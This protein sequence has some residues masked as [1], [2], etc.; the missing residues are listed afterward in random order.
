MANYFISKENNTVFEVKKDNP[1]LSNSFKL[2]AVVLIFAIAILHLYS[3]TF[4]HDQY[5]I[6]SDL[7]LI[8][9]LILVAYI[10]MQ[11]LR[12][13]YRLIRLN[14]SLSEAHEQLKHAEIDTIAA[15]ILIEESKDP[16]M[17][18]HSK[19]V[20]KL[21]QA[22]AKEM[23]LSEEHQMIVARAGILHDIGKIGIMDSVLNKVG[24]LNEEEWDIIKKHTENAKEI[25]EPLQFL[26][27]E[28]KII[29][30]HH[31]RFDGSGYPKGLSGSDLPIEVQVI[32]V[33]DAFDAMNSE[34]A[35]R[36]PLPRETIFE[37]LIK[38]KGSQ[39]NPEV[40]D[41]FI[42]MLENNTS[43]WEKNDS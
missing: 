15:L 7:T 18:G 20:A 33:A 21:S 9:V 14:K 38:A 4:L 23:G 22:I 40:V 27:R 35:Y 42:K 37:E 1:F 32:A 10:W 2:W 41:V 5:L 19:R 30:H 28:K 13:R 26:T 12:D 39:L 11:E 6:S 36:K 31:E 43:L 24:E 34:R 17:H 8:A 3:K 25:L 29:R 16:Y